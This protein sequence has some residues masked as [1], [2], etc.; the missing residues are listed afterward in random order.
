MSEIEN[1]SIFSNL[2][3]LQIIIVIMKFVVYL[4]YHDIEE[5]NFIQS[6]GGN[7]GEETT[8]QDTPPEGSKSSNGAKV[9]DSAKKVATEAGAG[10]L[11]A[12]I[13]STGVGA[14]AA[15]ALKMTGANKVVAGA[16][17]DVASNTV[18][19]ATS[20]NKSDL[21]KG[22]EDDLRNDPD[23]KGIKKG[24]INNNWIFYIVKQSLD[25]I[26]RVGKT[27]GEIVSRLF[28]IFIFAATFPVFPFF[29]VM[30][31][32]YAFVKYGAFKIR[33]L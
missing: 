3:F 26:T 4:D 6:G 28:M 12:G 31:L 9:P 29:A 8:K 7:Q 11:T 15:A 5:L 25:I 22:L 14:P 18:E 27:A 2:S 21:D 23:M 16:A 1:K 30:G 24:F 32:M 10:A 19:N 20:S 13:A 17:V 33:G